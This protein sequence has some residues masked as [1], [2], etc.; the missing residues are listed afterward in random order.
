M[1]ANRFS[2]LLPVLL[3]AA[4]PAQALEATR[5]GADAL[6]AQYTAVF[7][8]LLFDQGIVAIDPKG[9]A[10]QISFDGEKAFARLNLPG[11]TLKMKP[12]VYLISP[13]PDSA[14]SAHGTLSPGMQFFVP[15]PQGDLKGQVDV[16]GHQFDAVYDPKQTELFRSSTHVES[17]EAK[18]HLPDP[19]GPGA[20][21]DISQS[22]L[23]IDANAT[24]V[25]G[26]AISFSIRESIKSTR[27]VMRFVPGPQQGEPLNVT[28]GFGNM[29]AN[30]TL[31]ALRVSG[32][33]DMVAWAMAHKDDAKAA[34]TQAEAK[35]RLLALLPLWDNFGGKVTVKDVTASMPQGSMAMQSLFESLSIS[36]LSSKA[37]AQ[38]GFGFRD[39]TVQS[40]LLPPWSAQLLPLSFDVNV[41][42]SVEGVDQAVRV[43]LED[44]DLSTKAPLSKAAEARIAAILMN[45]SPKVTLAPGH[46]TNPLIDISYEGEFRL[47]NAKPMGHCVVTADGLDK[48]MAFLQNAAN[49]LPSPQHAILALTFAKGL[50]KAGPDGKLV[51]TIDFTDERSVTVNGQRFPPGG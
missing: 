11:A 43:A 42:A 21:L 6:I 38:F 35:S 25:D 17:V 16:Q 26:G 13:R 20:D 12:L 27:E 40:S 15:T 48:A 36:G 32:L 39:L 47:S 45:G 34:A 4:V 28:F 24:S 33:R 31:A 41:S 10:Y 29:D 44:T 46:L 14:W 8:P 51:W 50:A 19:K 2:S 7:G 22:G 3:L 23:A 37:Q 18:M 30:V 49:S 9:D 1:R 5:Q